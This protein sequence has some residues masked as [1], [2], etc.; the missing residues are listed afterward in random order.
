MAARNVGINST[1]EQQRQVINQIAVDVY[2]LENSP[3]SGITTNNIQSWDA[4]YGW[5]NHALVGYLTSYTE[6]DPIF[7]SSAASGISTNDISDWNTAYSWGNHASQG[8]L[9]NV[10]I[11]AG[12]N[13]NVVESSEGNFI[14]TAT[15]PNSGISGI[16]IQEEGNPVGSSGSIT[17]INFVGASVTATAIGQTATIDISNIIGGAI[18]GSAGTWAVTSVGIHTIKNVGIGTT[19]PTSSL[20]VSGDGIF[21]GIVTASRFETSVSGTPSIDSP[22]NFNINAVTVAISTDLT[23]GGDIGVTGIITASSVISNDFVGKVYIPWTK[24]YLNTQSQVKPPV[25][26]VSNSSY[27]GRNWGTWYT[28]T[29]LNFPNTANLSPSSALYNPTLSGIGFTDDRFTGF[30]Q[31]GTYDFCVQVE[32][33]DGVGRAAEMEL[34]SWES[35]VGVFSNQSV[36]YPGSS[37][38]NNYLTVHHSTLIT[39]EDSNPNNNWARYKLHSGI[40]STYYI[41]QAIL[42]IK[43]IA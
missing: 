29:F 5:G 39:F 13:I 31:G 32:I 16:S 28:C 33:Y 12:S 37:V 19:N 15:L 27:L 38:G 18:A 35:S 26:T 42:D 10:S 17:T 43:K 20:T 8:Y 34:Y 2:D 7:L 4:S 9:T 3:Y 30:E 14:I 24:F 36:W 25:S 23:V 41:G 1:F 11:T 6:T 40:T 21:T 22:N